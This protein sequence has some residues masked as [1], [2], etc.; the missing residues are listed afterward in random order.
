MP[1]DA[2][3]AHARA[4]AGRARGREGRWGWWGDKI[5]GWSWDK[6]F[7]GEGTMLETPALSVEAGESMPVESWSFH[8]AY[9]GIGNA[10]AGFELAGGRCTG[11]F[12]RCGRTRE[13]YTNRFGREPLGAWGSFGLE[14]MGEADVLFSAPPCEASLAG[15]GRYEDMQLVKQL[16][17]VE[18]F[19]YKVVVVELLLQ[20]KK[21]DQGKSF[22]NFTRRLQALGYAVQQKMLFAPDYG[23]AAARR[24]LVVVGTRGG[25]KAVEF[26]FPRGSKVH[27]PLYSVL[28][29][30]FFRREV[31]VGNKG[32]KRLATPKQRSSACLKQVGFMS[33]QGP[34]RTVYGPD[35]FASTQT[36]TGKGE[37]WTCGL[38]LVNGTVSRLTVREVARLM[39]VEDGV[40]LDEVEAVARRH[41]GSALPVGMARAVAVQVEQVLQKQKVVGG[42]RARGRDT[43]TKPRPKCARAAAL[44]AAGYAEAL[45]RHWGKMVAWQAASKAREQA[46]EKR[47]RADM[48]RYWQLDG[49]SRRMLRAGVQFLERRRWLKLQ[50]LRGEQEVERMRGEGAEP[51]LVRKAM[52]TVRKALYL[53][54]LRGDQEDG[55]INL[56]WWNW[57]GPIPGELMQG[58]TLPFRRPPVAVFPDNY[59]SADVAKVWEEFARMNQRGYMEGPYAEGGARVYMTH[60]M[61]AVAKKGSEKLRIVIDMTASLLNDCLI[62]HR[63]ILPQVHDVAAKCYPG[64]FLM[65]ADL[66]DGFYGVEVREADRK[67]LGVRHPAT[68]DLW[69]YTGL[70][71]GAACSPSAFSRLVAWAVRESLKY[72]EFKSVRVV[73][74]DTDPNMP[75]VYGVGADGLPVATSSWFVDDGCIIAPTR[76][77]CLAAYRRLVW[78]LEARLGWRICSRKTMGPAQRILFCGLELD[79]VG[80]DVNGPCTRLSEE[81]RQKCITRLDEFIKA[82]VWRRKAGGREMASII[83]ELSFAAN[84]IPAGRCFLWRLYQA[85]HEVGEEVKGHSHDYDREVALTVPAIL[86]LQ[87]WRE[88]LQHAACVRRWRTGSFALHRCWSDASDYGFAESVAVEEK[89]ELPRMQFTHGVWPEDV[90][91]FT[92][93]WHELATIVHSIKTRLEE[94]RG[95]TVHYMTDN[96]TA[97]R[98]VN[99]GTVSSVALM[100]LARELKQ[101][102]ARGDIRVEALHLPGKMMIAQGTDGASRQTPWLG[103]YSGQPGQHDTY[104]PLDWPRFPLNGEIVQAI[105]EVRQED[106]LDISDPATWSTELDTAGR[107]TFCHAR[108]CHAAI[109]MELLLEGQLREG[110][111][112]SFTMVVPFQM[113]MSSWS[114]FLRHFRTKRVFRVRVPGLGEMKHWFLRFERGDG[115]L[116][117][118]QA[119]GSEREGSEEC[120]E[121]VC[122]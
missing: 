46:L 4:G 17:L 23:S 99:T 103:M 86:D 26:E 65:T 71:M 95:S 25:E 79:T 60:P 82:H 7:H 52:A 37:G 91:G 74:N 77:K 41:L 20:S 114:R 110:R 88:C 49:A 21:V 122:D 112:T 117:R 54:W 35:S 47:T 69:R 73:I 119:E 75:R 66:V 42:G 97:V 102:E 45:V 9:C 84:A 36:A 19:R 2:R 43:C 39:Q 48:P 70:A 63:F 68:G 5:E 116:P 24:R 34:G 38:Y 56:M 55:P 44:T 94:L 12:D 67:Y 76:E 80:R 113:G 58:F 64:A 16:E 11:A 62:A 33:G 90:A 115:L 13:V 92:S 85:V 29:P 53:E 83:G 6:R 31:R 57:E 1:G 30:E 8:D 111:T 89:G 10:T 40:E 120:E 118:G 28:E 105:E 32:F 22:R 108:P 109:A 15:Q 78:I 14:Q 51:A 87:W 104:S 96:G 59:D 27:H 93:N 98:A 61:A 106:T 50:R 81:R 18:K 3:G 101:L 72:E 100:K 121:G 107:D